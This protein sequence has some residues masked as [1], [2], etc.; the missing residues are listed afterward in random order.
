MKEIFNTIK[1]SKALY[2]SVIF[3]T[4]LN[5][6]FI[7][8]PIP[9]DPTKPILVVYLSRAKFCNIYLEQMK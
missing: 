7:I 8:S 5:A 9:I 2:F 4:V 6:N 1:S 3:I